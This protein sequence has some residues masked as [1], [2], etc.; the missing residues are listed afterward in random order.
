MSNAPVPAPHARGAGDG[1]GPGRRASL[2]RRAGDP[3]GGEV[4]MLPGE[5]VYL[6]RYAKS[7]G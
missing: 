2:G 5:Q 7:S 3:V 4:S 1:D 6:T